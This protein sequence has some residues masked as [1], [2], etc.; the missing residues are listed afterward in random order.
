[1]RKTTA[2][3]RT[4]V[5]SS[6]AIAAMWPATR[7]PRIE[8]LRS[9]QLAFGYSQEDLRMVIAPMAAKKPTH[10]RQNITAQRFCSFLDITG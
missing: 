3:L 7:A 4:I 1:M 5:L 9:K 2:P 6:G 8:P 10:V